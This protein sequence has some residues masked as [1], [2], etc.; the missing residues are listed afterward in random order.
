MVSWKLFMG[1]SETTECHGPHPHQ[2]KKIHTDGI[3]YC[4]FL[5]IL[6]I[7][8]TVKTYVY[9]SNAHKFSLFSCLG[10]TLHVSPPLPQMRI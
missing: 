10:Q 4:Y 1:E 7:H 2:E 8:Y 5:G 6:N 3:S 9:S